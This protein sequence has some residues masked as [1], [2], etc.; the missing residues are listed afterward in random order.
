VGS[1]DGRQQL[2]R[3]SAR[4]VLLASVVLDVDRWS[5]ASAVVVR[6][7]AATASAGLPDHLQ[8]LGEQPTT[9]VLVSESAM[10]RRRREGLLGEG[11]DVG[12]TGEGADQESNVDCFSNL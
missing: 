4:W 5:S 8:F 12:I 6:G 2:Q 11:V 1:G 9:T 7:E 10:M 3:R